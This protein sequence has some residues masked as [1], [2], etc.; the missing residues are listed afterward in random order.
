MPI[1]EKLIFATDIIFRFEKI[2]CCNVLK[3][4]APT[5]SNRFHFFGSKIGFDISLFFS[6]IV[7]LSIRLLVSAILQW[8]MCWCAHW[9]FKESADC[10]RIEKTIKLW[11]WRC[12]LYWYIQTNC[13]CNKHSTPSIHLR[14]FQV[15]KVDS[16]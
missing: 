2:G 8:P 4:V 16:C 10:C 3:S 5:K 7:G 13:K 12:S 9:H 15:K 1:D 11:S 14:T 6:F